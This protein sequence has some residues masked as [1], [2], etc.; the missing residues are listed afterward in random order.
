MNCCLPSRGGEYLSEKQLDDEI[1]QEE[2]KFFNEIRRKKQRVG[3][4]DYGMIQTL[5]SKLDPNIPDTKFQNNRALHY[6]ARYGNIRLLHILLQAGAD[7]NLGNMG[8][9]TPLM[10][11]CRGVKSNHFKCVKRLLE[12]DGC[13]IEAKDLTG[14]TALRYA[15]KSSSVDT[16]RLLLGNNVDL[17]WENDLSSYGK[18]CVVALSFAKSIRAMKAGIEQHK[19]DAY[20][21]QPHTKISILQWIMRKGIYSSSHAI[22]EMIESSLDKHE[23]SK[24][25]DNLKCRL[26][27]RFYPKLSKKRQLSIIKV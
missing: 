18:C 11:A 10:I 17:N 9:L 6:A 27:H 2:E 13:D 21:T 12:I 22:V 26:S 8:G 20:F 14:S 7:P 15:I 19:A 23:E 4:I 16:V 25:N 1:S 3:G 5:L 24:S